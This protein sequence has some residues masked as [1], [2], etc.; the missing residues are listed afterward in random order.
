MIDPHD[1][2]EPDPGLDDTVADEELAPQDDAP[3]E[4]ASGSDAQPVS[5]ANP[6]IPLSGP[7]QDPSLN[8]RP[9]PPVPVFGHSVRMHEEDEEDRPLT[10]RLA[11]LRDPCERASDRRWRPDL[12]DTPRLAED[13]SRSTYSPRSRTDLDDIFDRPEELVTGST[14]EYDPEAGRTN[15][16]IKIQAVRQVVRSAT[17][18]PFGR[19]MVSIPVALAG[20]TLS[21][22]AVTLQELWMIISACLITPLGAFLVYQRYQAWLGHKR[23][24]YRLL[25][26]L[27][28]DVSGFDPLK[29]NRRI[30]KALHRK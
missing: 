27:G 20:L 25:E 14:A 4:D 2:R 3:A 1:E 29:A 11:P 21:I 24:M 22:M 10:Q 15:V 23:Y 16:A 6:A 28:E 7:D 8:G 30:G 17:S 18:T 5:E 19:L 26:S 13:V 12:G 9:P